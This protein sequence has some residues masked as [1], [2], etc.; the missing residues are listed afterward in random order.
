MS[1]RSDAPTDRVTF[2]GPCPDP[3]AG[4]TLLGWI[5][6]TA[7]L[8]AFSAIARASA[9]GATSFNFATQADGVT[10]SYLT[11]G[12]NVVTPYALTV[13]QWTR[14]AIQRNGA[15]ATVWYGNETGPLASTSGPVGG[16]ANP[17]QITLWGRS[18]SDGS[19]WFQG[20]Q[21]YIRYY[22]SVLTGAEIASEL[23]AINPVITAG[24][25]A[26]WRL[27][28]GA[29]LADAS[30]NGRHLT[31]GSTALG[32]ADGPPITHPVTSTLASLASDLDGFKEAAGPVES[33]LALFSSLAGMPGGGAETSTVLCSSWAN[34]SDVPDRMRAELVAMDD[35]ELQQYLTR[36]SEILWALSGRRWYGGGC[37]ETVVLRS[38]PPPPGTASWPYHRSWSR[39]SCWGFGT[40]LDGRLYPARGDYV[41]SH[42]Q[43]PIAVRL[44]RSPVTDIVS[45][46]VDEAA[47]TAWRLVRSGWLERTDGQP[48]Q[49]CDDSTEITYRF[50]TPPPAGGRDSAVELGV[51]LAKSALG[52]DCQLP[53]RTTSMTRQGLTVTT[54]DPSD[55]L[56]RGRVGLP[57]VDLWLSAVN[58][59]SAPQASR[60]LSPD[61]PTAIRR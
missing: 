9:S 23:N 4:F 12:G 47:F 28:N 32:T 58:P 10:L 16:A 43:A 17:D 15:T 37:E 38:T 21:Q 40:W 56:D 27:T 35:A 53:A 30:G 51:E 50:G 25:F 44:P 33:T 8:N 24:L 42:A 39:C 1:A 22:S 36:A 61:L 34:T 31:A 57:G 19:E 60:V 13:M 59:T 45:V 7:D 49:V 6:P 14:F 20:D 5:R 46:T 48:W 3:A 54:L 2:T 52:L 55:Y 41:G 29:D 18:A 11:P 26:H